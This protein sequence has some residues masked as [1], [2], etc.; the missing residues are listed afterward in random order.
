MYK[1]R[2][3]SLITAA[4]LLSMTFASG[5]KQDG[6]ID[7]LKIITV[8]YFTDNT[9]FMTYDDS[10]KKGGYG[11][12]YLQMVANAAGWK[13]EYIYGTYND[14]LKQHRQGKIELFPGA[15][16][17]L[18]NSQSL[19]LP[20]YTMGTAVSC[21]YVRQGNYTISSLNPLT[22]NNKTIGV[23]KN[24]G[25]YSSLKNWLNGQNINS[26]ILE[27][28]SSKELSEALNEGRADAVLELDINASKGWES[29][30]RINT[31]NFYL[32]VAPGKRQ[33]LQE[34]NDALESITQTNPFTTETLHMKYY[35]S[36][37]LSTRTSIKEE[38]WLNRHSNIIKVGLL[39][40]DLPFSAYN[41]ATQKAE[42]A[43]VDYLKDMIAELN[44]TG[45]SLVFTF[46]ESTEK[47]VQALMNHEVDIIFPAISDFQAAEGKSI[48]ISE[49]V[50]NFRLGLVYN[51]DL[52]KTGF[53]NLSILNNEL[54]KPVISKEFP[55][56][57]I[58][59]F[60]NPQACL[61]TVISGKADGAIFNSY[62]IQSILAKEKQFKNLGYMDLQ[63]SVQ[64][65]FAVRRTAPG[66]LT[67]INKGLAHISASERSNYME[68]YINDSYSHTLYSHLLEHW[69]LILVITLNILL[70]TVIIILALFKL[71]FYI[72]Y[73]PTSHLLTKRNL[74]SRILATIKESLSE[75]KTFCLLIL[76][77]DDFKQMMTK[78]NR[79]T[80]DFIILITTKIVVSSIARNDT[81]FRTAND[82][83]IV[84]LKT[85]INAA[86]RTAARILSEIN[87]DPIE[88]K[89]QKINLTATIGLAEYK[90]GYTP[91]TLYEAADKNLFE[92]KNTGKN[93]V[94]W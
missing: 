44:L 63:K 27:V 85:D 15:S 55:D 83:I 81:P 93:K 2:I 7:S 11:Y 12:D 5:Q 48:M 92:G 57:Q 26:R 79:S 91:K 94:V 28:N 39:S 4:F 41:K 6:E 69:P 10:N 20:R 3:L 78:Y 17:S 84:I 65:A 50:F 87:S 90:Q 77:L 59:I 61:D 9:P 36:S 21:I 88:Y 43:A 1:K 34:L 30:F 54:T 74:N 72:R 18:S 73:D 45:V 22:L 8:A 23:I 49:P 53:R 46:A 52:A 16:N 89:N 37:L 80:V 58:Q 19:L 32:S 70:V 14:L 42:G 25:E 24:S 35:Y 13:Y 68:H 71:Q 33:L 29:V 82:Q 75:N 31:T 56:C 60:T 67:L 38:N 40:N 47:L 51:K 66:L 62:R 86:R 64:F 76:E